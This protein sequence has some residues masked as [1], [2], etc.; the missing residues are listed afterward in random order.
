[1]VC[2][3]PCPGPCLSTGTNTALSFLFPEPA[4]P[5]SHFLS[6]LILWHL[7]QQQREEYMVQEELPMGTGSVEL[8][9]QVSSSDLPQPL[10]SDCP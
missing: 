3:E 5:E 6:G 10:R 4:E 9:L 2:W 1:M 7:Q 8:S